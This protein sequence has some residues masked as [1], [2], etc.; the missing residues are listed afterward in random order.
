M[1][2]ALVDERRREG[3]GE[4]GSGERGSSKTRLGHQPSLASGNAQRES[5]LTVP[6]KGCAKRRERKRRKR[7]RRKKCRGVEGQQDNAVCSVHAHV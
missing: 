6:Q 1:E 2:R 3:V 4:E 5:K 7:G